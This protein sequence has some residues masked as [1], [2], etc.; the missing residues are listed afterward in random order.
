M[1]V[2]TWD[3]LIVTIGSKN[4]IESKKKIVVTYLTLPRDWS[5]QG[6]W[7]YRGVA[8]QEIT[9]FHLRYIVLETGWE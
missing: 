8:L 3:P 1:L 5:H 7:V 6:I 4:E 9:R 2:S